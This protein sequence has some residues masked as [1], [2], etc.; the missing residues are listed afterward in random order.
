LTT[1]VRFALQS[2]HQAILVKS[3]KC[4]TGTYSDNNHRRQSGSPAGDSPITPFLSCVS[5]SREFLDRFGGQGLATNSPFAACHFRYFYPGYTSH[6]LAFDRDHG[7]SQFLDD[8]ALLIRAEYFLNEVDL[9]QRHDRSPMFPS[10]ERGAL[11]KLP[12]AAKQIFEKA[13]I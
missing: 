11:A 2:G 4:Q 13:L 10:S 12:G 5:A 7:V 1:C 9:Y 6:V 8:L 3:P